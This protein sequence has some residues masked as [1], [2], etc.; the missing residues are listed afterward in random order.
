VIEIAETYTH[1]N[2]L[3]RLRRAM[4][5][6]MAALYPEQDI[7]MEQWDMELYDGAR[8]LLA[9]D[10]QEAV[11]CCGLQMNP[12]TGLAG[13]ELK[14]MYVAPD[15]RGS[16]VADALMRSVDDFARGRGAARVYLETGLRQSAACRVYERNGYSRIPAYPPY[17]SSAIS[18]CYA[19]PVIHPPVWRSTVAADAALPLSRGC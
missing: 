2:D 16:G 9:R 10:G 11:G 4:Y 17:T 7:S 14:R 6:E 12:G 15:R 18:V 13:L 1:D 19:K 3:L 8:F 5:E